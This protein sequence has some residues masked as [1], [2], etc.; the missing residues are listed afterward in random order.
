MNEKVLKGITAIAILLVAMGAVSA[1]SAATVTTNVTNIFAN[2]TTPIR[3]VANNGTAFDVSV[4]VSI[5]SSVVVTNGTFN[6]T[7]SGTLVTETFTVTKTTNYNWINISLGGNSTT[8]VYI[9]TTFNASAS[10]SPYLISAE[11]YNNTTN[12]TL[13]N[14]ANTT[15]NATNVNLTSNITNFFAGVNTP[16]QLN[17]STGGYFVA[18]EINISVS[19]AQFVNTSTSSTS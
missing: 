8:T 5:P 19:G 9:N 12:P 3:I 10:A 14:T 13:V 6:Y 15:F 2:V 4:N 1:V 11:F 16:I 17:A 18:D 7:T